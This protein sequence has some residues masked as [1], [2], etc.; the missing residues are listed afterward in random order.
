[1]VAVCR[2]DGGF[3]GKGSGEWQ[4]MTGSKDVLGPLGAV[5]WTEMALGCQWWPHAKNAALWMHL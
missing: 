4:L 5:R 3:R 2:L 1:M